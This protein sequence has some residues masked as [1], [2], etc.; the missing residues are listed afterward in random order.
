MGIEE[1]SPL[2]F[3]RLINSYAFAIHASYV[4]DVVQQGRQILEATLDLGLISPPDVR[5]QSPHSVFA[6]LSFKP[7]QLNP[8]RICRYFTCPNVY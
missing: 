6:L 8:T 7:L 2:L 4:G 5:R 3:S 1:V